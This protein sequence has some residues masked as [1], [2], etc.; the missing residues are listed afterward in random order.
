MNPTRVLQTSAILGFLAVL[1][2]AFGAHALHDQLVANERLETWETA[3]FY[4]FIHT[5][6]LL[7]LSNKS[8]APKWPV[9]LF[10]AGIGIFS[11]SLYVL[12]LTQ[13]SKLGAITPLGGLALMGGWLSLLVTTKQPKTS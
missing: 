4:H 1:L 7:W 11:G 6:V 13:I 3:V 10:L 8:P 12:C 9:I 2:G 5:L